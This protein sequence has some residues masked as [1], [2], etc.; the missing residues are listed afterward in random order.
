MKNIE[1]SLKAVSDIIRIRILLLLLDREAC[2]CELMSVLQMSQSKLS[3]HLIILRNTGLLSDDKRGKWNYYV[4]RPKSLDRFQRDLVFSL[5][6]SFEA[7]EM[8]KRDRK[9]LV[10]VKQRMNICC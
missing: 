6:R 1:K 2:V 10:E 3:H 8:I 5:R 7:H 4:L 9:T